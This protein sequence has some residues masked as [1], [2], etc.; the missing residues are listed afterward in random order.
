MFFF[1][2]SA[3]CTELYLL[4]GLRLSRSRTGAVR[5]VCSAGREGAGL[6]T[7]AQCQGAVRH[8]L[9]AT[10]FI[11]GAAQIC[12]LACNTSIPLISE[13]PRPAAAEACRHGI[14]PLSEPMPHPRFH[15]QTLVRSFSLKSTRKGSALRFAC[16]PRGFGQKARTPEG[17]C[18]SGQ[19]LRAPVE[20]GMVPRLQ[21]QE[22]V[23][24]PRRMPPLSPPASPLR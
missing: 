15:S 4:C 11:V 10:L 3:R 12:D 24:C 18:R 6:G 2:S 20:R 7:C 8:P 16:R 1:Q 21:R 19:T 5:A 14:R 13:A 17:D 9:E 22:P 23:P